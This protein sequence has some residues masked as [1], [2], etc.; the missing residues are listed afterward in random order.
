MTDAT[1]IVRGVF[2][3]AMQEVEPG[4]FRAD[5]VGELNPANPDERAFPDFHLGTSPE[6]VKIWVEQ[7]AKALGYQ[8]VVWD[9]LPEHDGKGPA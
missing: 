8:R 1:P 4:L 2:H 6:A 9:A 3:A 7:M 5:Y